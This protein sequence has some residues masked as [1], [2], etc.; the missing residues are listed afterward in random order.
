MIMEQPAIKKL[1]KG[2]KE[3]PIQGFPDWGG[4]PKNLYT[5]G[6]LGLFCFSFY[7]G[8]FGIFTTMIQRP[9]H[10]LFML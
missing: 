10:L 4:I 9:V 2:A 7:S 5:L 3:I 1:S 6:A 8:V